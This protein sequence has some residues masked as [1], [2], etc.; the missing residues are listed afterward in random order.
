MRVINLTGF[1]FVVFAVFI[2]NPIG[3]L[4]FKLTL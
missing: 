1:L 4:L 3:F 2:I